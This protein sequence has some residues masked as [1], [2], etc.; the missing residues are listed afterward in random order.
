M[1]T[2]RTLR[3]TTALGLWVTLGL[4]AAFY[5]TWL[6]YGG[7]RF[8]IALAVWML[9]LAG[10][11]LAAAGDIRT[12]VADSLAPSGQALAAVVLP[13]FAYVIYAAGTNSLEWHRAALAVGYVAAPSLL[14]FRA[15]QRPPGTWEDYAAALLIWLP[16]EFRWL[17]ELTRSRWAICSQRFLR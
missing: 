13:L 17:R 3:L 5:A 9:L 7:R 14:T 4:V 2:P 10:Q 11:L 15:R 8:A 12:R 6:G 16:V 1:S